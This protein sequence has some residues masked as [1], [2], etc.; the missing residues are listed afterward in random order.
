MLKRNEHELAL[1][2]TAKRVMPGGGTGNHTPFPHLSEFIIRGGR[3]GHV[4]DESGNEYIDFLLGSGPMLIGHAHP[5]VTAAVREQIEQGTTFLVNNRH[6]ILL[7][8]AIVDAVP[9]ADQV[10][11]VSTGTEADAYVIRLARAYRNHNKILKFEGAYHGM[12]DPALTNLASDRTGN[13]P[14]AV[15]GSPGIPQAISSDVLIAPFNDIDTAASLIDEY[16]DELAGVIIEPLQRIIPAKPAFIEGL[17]ELT[18]KHDIPYIF[19]EVVTGFSA[20]LRR[21]ASVLWRNTGSLARWERRVAAAIHSLPL[22]GVRKSWLTLIQ[23][24]LD[25]SASWFKLAH[26][27]AIRWPP[28]PG[29]RH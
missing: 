17:R 21:C 9:C 26:Y 14:Q 4:W 28:R 13:L 23:A 3:A 6:A 16:A 5:A 12:S 8:E 2:E 22:L 10:R 29:W 18:A 11:F 1:V 20:C 7:A 24:G 25:R 19:D 15:P 27:R